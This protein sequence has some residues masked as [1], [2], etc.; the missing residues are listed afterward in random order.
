M[1]DV[2]VKVL[3]PRCPE[4]TIF[5]LL[6]R[7]LAPFPRLMRASVGDGAEERISERSFVLEN[8]LFFR[9][10]LDKILGIVSF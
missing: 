8:E 1:G 9:T 3:F 6:L 4:L 5:P 7:L 10:V 2:P